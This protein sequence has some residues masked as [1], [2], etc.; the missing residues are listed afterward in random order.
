M[1]EL[2]ISV[3][4][5]GRDLEWYQMCARAV[6]IFIIAILFLRLSGRRSFGMK[7][8]FDNTIAILI[9]A[10]LSRPVV[11]ASPFIPTMCAAL[12]LALMHRLFAWLSLYFHSFGRLIK[13]APLPLFEHGHFNKANMK[14]AL[15][16]IRDIE[17]RLR[18]NAN[19]C[20][21]EEVEAMYLER[22]GEISVVKKKTDAQSG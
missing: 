17:E 8:P 14:R 5:Q 6:V 15:I 1:N 9:G 22:N 2:L 3:F 18:L 16:S 13:G 11:G 12:V 19:A 4:G 7:S 21:L 10:V 20:T